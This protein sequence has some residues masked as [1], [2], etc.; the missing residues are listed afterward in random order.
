MTDRMM[1]ED[2]VCNRSCKMPVISYSNIVFG[3]RHIPN[4]KCLV[5][6]LRCFYFRNRNKYMVLNGINGPFILF[7]L[8]QGGETKSVMAILHRDSGSLGFNIVGGRPCA[9]SS[10]RFAPPSYVSLAH[11]ISCFSP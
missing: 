6:K 8:F 11:C 5:W 1:L 9:V 2:L 10:E 4:L 3:F 7:F